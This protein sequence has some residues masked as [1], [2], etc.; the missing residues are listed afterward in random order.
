MIC[1]I[2]WSSCQFKSVIYQPK[3]T[4]AM[5]SRLCPSILN[6]FIKPRMF[7][8]ILE[9]VVSMTER[10][11]LKSG[12]YC[13]YNCIYKTKVLFQKT[14]VMLGTNIVWL[15]WASDLLFNLKTAIYQPKHEEQMNAKL[16]SL[17]CDGFIKRAIIQQLIEYFVSMVKRWKLKSG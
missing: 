9:C 17:V 13:L 4:K 14:E 6:G 1:L 16:C 11:K 3:D 2:S 15:P 8:E 7:W 5:N 10:R 12:L